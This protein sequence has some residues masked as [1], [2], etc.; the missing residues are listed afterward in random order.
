MQ[1]DP[2]AGFANIMDIMLVFALG[3]ILALIAQNEE[4][5]RHFQLQQA[6]TTEVKPGK[7]LVEAPQSINEAINGDG[8][9]MKPLGKVYR[10]PDTGK[11]IL[12]ESN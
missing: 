9:G 6:Q 8:T 10:D 11:L 3:L 1:D 4:M 2:L 5:R 12:V 7:E